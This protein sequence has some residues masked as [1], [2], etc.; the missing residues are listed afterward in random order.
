MKLRFSLNLFK[1]I[2]FN[3]HQFFNERDSRLLKHV[4]CY[5]QATLLDILNGFLKFANSGMIADCSICS[6]YVE[7][8][9][10]VAGVNTEGV[11][12]SPFPPPP[13]SLPVS[14]VLHMLRRLL[15]CLRL[16]I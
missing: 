12:E 9:A 8:L 2:L 16:Q 13:L 10:C 4:R 5:E 3:K 15:K 7:M 6:R 14:P 11:G 1:V